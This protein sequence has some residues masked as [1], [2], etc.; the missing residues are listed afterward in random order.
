MPRKKV[1]LTANTELIIEK[2][3]ARIKKARLRR[4]ISAEVLSEQA[5]ISIG[6]LYAIEKGTSTVSI[7]AYAA[8]LSALSMESDIDAIAV[9]AEGKQRYRDAM[10]Y[11]RE[12]ASKKLR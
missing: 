6:T 3:G 1:V 10:I 9:D 4:N 8:V 11:R 7:G 12:R 5:R 2:A